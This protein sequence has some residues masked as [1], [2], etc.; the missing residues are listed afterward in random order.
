MSKE[1][2]VNILFFGQEKPSIFCFSERRNS[3]HFILWTEGTADI[4]FFGQKK[5]STIFQTEEAV[6]I[7]FFGQNK[8]STFYFSEKRNC[9]HFIFRT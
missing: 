9:G 7:L 3:Q 4:L 8:R 2:A 5:P 1:K 6:D